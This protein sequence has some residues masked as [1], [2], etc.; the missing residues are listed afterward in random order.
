[1]PQLEDYVPLNC[2]F[3]LTQF[4]VGFKR[5]LFCSSSPFTLSAL[6]PDEIRNL[7]R[8][9]GDAIEARI[10][11]LAVLPSNVR[12][13]STGVIIC[14]IVGA[15]AMVALLL[16]SCSIA[17]ACPASIG[18]AVQKVSTR[19]QML[20]HFCVGMLCCSPY[21]ALVAVQDDVIRPA[22]KLPAWVQAEAGEVFRVSIAT[23]TFAVVFAALVAVL[24]GWTRV[25]RNREASV[26]SPSTHALTHV[27]R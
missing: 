18:R 13:L 3:G 14:L 12:D 2:S 10:G 9:L 4:C 27:T 8:P 20:I 6:V 26:N 5:S 16:L 17:Y 15:L 7:P 23:L 22:Q 24:A 21:V 25:Q 11:E 1:M 19:K